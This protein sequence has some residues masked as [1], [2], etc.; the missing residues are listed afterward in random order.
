[1]PVTLYQ[2][3]ALAT[4]DIIKNQ[5]KISFE[6]GL[7]C[8][9]QI[10]DVTGADPGRGTGGRVTFPKVMVARKVDNQPSPHLNVGKKMPHPKLDSG[11]PRGLAEARRSTPCSEMIVGCT[12]KL[13]VVSRCATWCILKRAALQGAVLYRGS[14]FIPE[15]MSPPFRARSAA[16][17]RGD[18]GP[19]R[20]PPHPTT[21]CPPVLRW[22][23]LCSAWPVLQSNSAEY[24]FDILLSRWG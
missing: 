4:Y 7:D 19:Y 22:A 11:S 15:Q 5:I 9:S 21:P 20:A 17:R 12:Q 14:H 18:P 23:P 2:I 8:R 13:C 16:E 6:N 1:M 24:P 3:H 10:L